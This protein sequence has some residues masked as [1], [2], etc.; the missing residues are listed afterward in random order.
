[1][2]ALGRMNRTKVRPLPPSSLLRITDT[3]RADQSVFWQGTFSYSNSDNAVYEFFLP[4]NASAFTIYSSRKDDRGRFLVNTVQHDGATTLIGSGDAWE[5]GQ[6]G[7]GAPSQPL[8][9][10]QMCVTSAPR[11]LLKTI[12]DLGAQSRRR[13]SLVPGRQR[14]SRQP[15]QWQRL[16]RHRFR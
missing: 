15:D 1:M 2:P 5:Q 14:R 3:I 8:F 7:L 6:G 12:P 16:P 10:Y 11:E 4:D 9:Y 13:S